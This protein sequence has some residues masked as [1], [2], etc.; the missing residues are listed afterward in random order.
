MEIIEFSGYLEEEKLEIGRH[1]LVPKQVREHGLE[2]KGVRFDDEALKII[3]SEYTREAGVRNFERETA[4][5]CRQNRSPG[6]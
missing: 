3:I 4:N 1:F 6:G 5:V 2:E